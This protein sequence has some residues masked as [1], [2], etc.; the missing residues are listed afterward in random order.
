[1]V[2]GIEGNEMSTPKPTTKKTPT[3]SA[4]GKQA[5]ILGFFAKKATPT[6]V[7]SRPALK[8]TPAHIKS[9]LTP[10]PS[11]DPVEPPSS[12]IKSTSTLVTSPGINKENGLPSPV[13]PPGV[14]EKADSRAEGGLEDDASPVRRV[15]VWILGVKHILIQRIG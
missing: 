6:A 5:S 14:C 12:A 10:V 3:S 13:T 15:S 1:M 9:N 2:R 7:P 11:S 4:G 8:P